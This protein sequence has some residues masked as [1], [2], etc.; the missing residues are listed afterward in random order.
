MRYERPEEDEQNGKGGV[1][2]RKSKS[3]STSAHGVCITECI[4]AR[5]A[6]PSSPLGGVAEDV[7][8]VLMGRD[9][10]APRLTALVV[11]TEEEEGCGRF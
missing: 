8:G 7:A 10:P 2:L 4:K 1:R 11:V 9:G 3:S 6:T 5:K